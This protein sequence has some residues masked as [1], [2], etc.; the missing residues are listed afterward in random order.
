MISKHKK[1][2][3]LTF[4]RSSIDLYSNDLGAPFEEITSFGAFVGGS[5]TNIAVSCSRLGLR[6]ALLTGIG[7]DQV[8]IFIKHFLDKE[9]I[10]T[11]FIPTFSGQ[12]LCNRCA[13]E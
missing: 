12:D 3:V 1:Y 13:Y 4:G 10:E 5:S 11:K 9:G 7:D 6:T 2:D 8:G